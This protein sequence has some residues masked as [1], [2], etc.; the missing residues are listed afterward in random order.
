LRF[1]ADRARLALSQALA[2]GPCHPAGRYGTPK[3]EETMTKKT[4]LLVDDDDTLRE[5]LAEQFGFEDDF[6]VLTA[7]AARPG[8]ELARKKRSI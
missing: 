5:A 6:E 1:T 7:D 8:M 3:D 4:I 2:Q